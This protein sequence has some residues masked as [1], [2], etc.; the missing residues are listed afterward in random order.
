[1]TDLER[2]DLGGS[3][4]HILPVIKG[5]RSEAEVVKMAFERVSPD[6]VGVSLSK[7]DVD[8][9]RHIPEDFE[10]DLTTYDQIYAAGL[11][12]F[13]E[14]AAPPPC[15]VAAVEMADHLGIPLIALDL[16]DESYTDLYCAAVSGSALFRHSTRTWLLRRRRFDAASPEEFVSAWDRAVNKLSAFRFIED[17]RVEAMAG[18]ILGHANDSRNL[19][20]IIELERADEVVHAVR[21]HGRTAEK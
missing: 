6:A 11:S 9:L 5:L 10:P 18:G 20:A 17:K 14:V 8:G 21:S 2:I 13:G 7:E 4:V 15:F 3:T 16:D 12:R 19:L 1:M